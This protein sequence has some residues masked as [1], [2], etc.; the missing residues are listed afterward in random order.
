[1]EQES[2]AVE[3]GCSPHLGLGAND[4]LDIAD[5]CRAASA[6]VPARV[7]NDVIGLFAE[8]EIIN[9]PI[10]SDLGRIVDHQLVIWIFPVVLIEPFR[11]AIAHGPIRRRLDMQLDGVLLVPRDVHE[12][13]AT[14]VVSVAGIELRVCSGEIIAKNFVSCCDDPL[15]SP[16]NPPG[17]VVHLVP[18]EWLI[19][20]LCAEL[21]NV[22]GKIGNGVPAGLPPGHLQIEERRCV[23]RGDR[24]IDCHFEQMGS[25]TRHG[26]PVADQIRG[27]SLSA[28]EQRQA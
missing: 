3:F 8:F 2:V 5:K 26:E 18:F 19:L 12:N 23:C 10:G 22:L 15:A 13:F 24:N 28:R 6:F 9:R 17:L 25:R 27:K 16:L 7:N 11:P 4:L 1:M 21:L 20:R 14:R